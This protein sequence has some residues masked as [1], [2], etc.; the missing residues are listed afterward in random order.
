MQLRVDGCESVTKWIFFFQN[1]AKVSY[2]NMHRGGNLCTQNPAATYSLRR[3]STVGW[4]PWSNCIKFSAKSPERR[5]TRSC[6]K[7]T[8]VHKHM[9][10]WV[11]D[12]LR[13]LALSLTH[14]RRLTPSDGLRR[15]KERVWKRKG[16]QNKYKLLEGDAGTRGAVSLFEPLWRGMQNIF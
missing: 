8:W 13:S 15:K 12:T 16:D 10:G 7:H 14:I 2:F 5:K 6:I 4:C 11:P 1:T 9:G 3:L